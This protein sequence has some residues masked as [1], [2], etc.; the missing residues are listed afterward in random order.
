MEFKFSKKRIVSFLLSIAMLFSFAAVCPT[1][2]EVEAAAETVWKF[3]FGNGGTA[4]GFT[5]VDASTSYDSSRGYGF[6]NTG[7]VTNVSASG[8]NE[9]SDAVRFTSTDTQN[10]FDVDLPNGLYEI[11]VYL[12]NTTRTSVRAEDCLQLI[13]LTGNN[14]TDT[15]QIP[16]TDG[17]LNIMATEGKANYPFTLSSLIIKKVSDDTTTPPT[18]WI[19]GDSTVC[20][21]YP[22]DTS[23]QA[24]WGQVLG[25]YIDTNYW[26]I[27]NLAASGQYAK[28]FVDSGCFDTIL[29]Y[30]KEGDIYIISIG[31]ND[32]NY[33]NSTE[34]KEVVGSMAQQ[35]T[36]KGMEVVLV[37][38]QGRSS[39]VSRSPLLTGRWFG[40][41]L[42]EI[43]SEQNLQVV[44]LFNLA[45]DY[46]ISI[47]Q[48][49]TYELYMDGDTLH[50]NREGAKVLAKI[51]SEQVDFSTI[52]HA[53]DTIY[54]AGDS[55][56][57]SYNSSY[58]P[59]QGWGYYLKD[60]L[61]Y[62][63]SVVNRAIAGRSSK[64]F[65]DQGRLQS[66]LDIIEDGDYLLVQFGINDASS[67]NAERY[68]PICGSVENA[69]EGSYEY[70]IKFYVE[71]AL[72][73]GATPVLISPVLGLKSYSN[74]QFVPSY[75][76]HADALQK[77]AD[78][79]DVP[80]IN[81]NQL[82]VDNYNSI[83]YDAAYK[84]HMCGAVD[85]STDMT[86]FCEAGA[87]NAAKLLASELNDVIKEIDK[88]NTQKRGAYI[89]NGKYMIKGYE[90]GLYLD[91]AG[92]TAANGT[93][94]QIW[95]AYGPG[96][97]NTWNLKSAGNGYYQIYS[98]VG[99]GSYLLDLDYGKTDDGTN[100]QI[101]QNTYCD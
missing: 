67:S 65:Y 77:I 76:G 7:S 70:Y 89:P 53:D 26:L 25:E 54:I 79:Y 4:S 44:D 74:G 63:F 100:I 80:F 8:S 51:I 5:G 2:Y 101:Y 10:T 42:D 6:R 72:E 97:Q 50:P 83:G 96:S 32:T 84:F 27:R 24:G 73:K 30:G 1:V 60:Y 39:D 68:A 37:K 48:D 88:G 56:V 58:A 17:Q 11:T 78:Y 99:D 3:D 31:I 52:S 82:M 90:S 29:K 85:G 98:C 91:V 92:G 41:Q 12:G 43:G 55:T 61:D 36:A 33:S 16:I 35:A 66:I 86:H 15:F 19:C 40:T 62:D 23:T 38:Q 13:N 14:A 71:G 21:Y 46:F 69:T 22:L 93:N 9:L 94:V 57:Q 95:G 75:T 81:L 18:V 20:N 34:Y 45:Q 87:E 64:S 49:A 28:G 59:Q 47:G